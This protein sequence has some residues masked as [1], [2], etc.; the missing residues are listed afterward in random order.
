MTIMIDEEDRTVQEIADALVRD[1]DT[2]KHVLQMNK[3]TKNLEK[4]RKYLM[5]KDGVYAIRMRKYGLTP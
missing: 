1:V 2:I 5:E 4:T 3:Y